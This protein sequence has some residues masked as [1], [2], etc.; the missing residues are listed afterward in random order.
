[1]ADCCSPDC[2]RFFNRRVAERDA[3]RYRAK[4]LTGTAGELAELAGDVTGASV[5]EVGGGIGTIE[6]ELLAAGAARATNVELS[7]AYE[8]AAHELIAER[9]LGDRVERRVADFAVEHATVEPHDVVVMHRVVCCYPDVDALVEA[10]AERARRRLVLTFPQDRL[11]LRAGVRIVNLFLRIGGGDFRVY[12]HR[13]AQ[14]A[15]AARRGGLAPERT[16]RHG[17]FWESA[18]FGNRT[19]R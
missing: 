4:G 6:L 17:L 12:V 10:A 7:P 18:A 1:M 9:G 15:E 8:E 16:V 3:R 14:I 5:L 2:G 13:R 19:A 11:L